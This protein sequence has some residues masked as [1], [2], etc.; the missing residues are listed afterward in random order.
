MQKKIKAVDSR[1]KTEI[2]PVL[3]KADNTLN[4]STLIIKKLRTSNKI[5]DGDY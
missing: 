4:N 2:S 5:Q 3:V 1:F